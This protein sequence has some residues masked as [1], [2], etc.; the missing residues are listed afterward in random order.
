MET[1]ASFVIASVALFSLAIIY[2]SVIGIM[3]MH[4]TQK[5]GFET[6]Q[7]EMAKLEQA[8]YSVGENWEKTPRFEILTKVEF[9]E[10]AKVYRLEVMVFEQGKNKPLV[11]LVRY[12]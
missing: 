7:L 8:S 9:N 5:D 3:L 11:N 10:I 4:N 2:R 1:T 12:E 6:A